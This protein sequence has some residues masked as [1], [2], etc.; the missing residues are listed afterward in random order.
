[1]YRNA[2]SMQCSKSVA[3]AVLMPG[4]RALE[5]IKAG[6]LLTREA[7]QDRKVTIAVEAIFVSRF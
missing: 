7:T 3:E 5:H 2:K 1:M 4:A 6:Q